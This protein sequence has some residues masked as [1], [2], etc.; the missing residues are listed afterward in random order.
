MRNRT[1]CFSRTEYGYP[2]STLRADNRQSY[3]SEWIS[4]QDG[5]SLDLYV[6]AIAHVCSFA[7]HMHGKI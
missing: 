3:G 2:G 5:K 6:A 1:R 4:L 7:T